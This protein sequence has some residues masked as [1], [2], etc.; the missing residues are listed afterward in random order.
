MDTIDRY[1]SGSL[2]FSDYLDETI[3]DMDAR[4]DIKVNYLS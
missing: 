1:N 2:N 3:Y 4:K